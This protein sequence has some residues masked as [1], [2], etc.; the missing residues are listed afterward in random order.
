MGGAE[1]KMV[2]KSKKA[3]GQVH[4]LTRTAG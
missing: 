3:R 1:A 2:P 4:W